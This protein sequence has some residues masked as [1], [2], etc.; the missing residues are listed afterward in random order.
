V[1]RAGADGDATAA[2]RRAPRDT[3]G[4]FSVYLMKITFAGAHFGD[5]W[6]RE[7]SR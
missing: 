2:A 7:E 4:E 1:S 6:R 3:G 5:G